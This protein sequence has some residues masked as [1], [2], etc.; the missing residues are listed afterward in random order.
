MYVNELLNMQA[1]GMIK[2]IKENSPAKRDFI[3]RFLK[4]ANA[5][6]AQNRA[7][8][9]YHINLNKLRGTDE[10]K[11]VPQVIEEETNNIPAIAQ[12]ADTFMNTLLKDYPKTLDKRVSL[13]SQGAVSMDKTEPKSRLRKLMVALNDFINKSLAE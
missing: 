6:N 13:L 5:E 1:S 8:M 2:S 11:R 7:L 3:N 10:F 9:A 12:E 4:T